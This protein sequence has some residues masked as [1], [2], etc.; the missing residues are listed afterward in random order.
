[1]SVPMKNYMTPAI[2]VYGPPGC[3]KSTHAPT[4]ARRYGCTRIIDEWDGRSALPEGALAL[5][6][7]EPPYTEP[8]RVLDFELE[9]GGDPHAR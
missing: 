7:V 6:N 2:I 4:F 5:T 3:G 9:F 1:M 8:G